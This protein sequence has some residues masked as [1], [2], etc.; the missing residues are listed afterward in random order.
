MVKTCLDLFSG[1]GGFS[2]AFRESDTWK[3]VKVDIR[4]KFN[5]DLCED[6]LDLLPTDLPDADVVL[7]SPPCVCF[8]NA[9]GGHHIDGEYNPRTEKAENHITLAFHTVGL[10]HAI[11]PDWWFLENPTAKLRHYLGEPEGK[12]TYCQYG[13]EYMKPTDLWGEHPPS[14][15]YRSCSPGGD[16]HI[17]GLA[18]DGT[19]ATASLPDSR[20]E[21][22]KVPYDLSLSIRESVEN[23][24]VK[25]Q[26]VDIW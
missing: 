4:E 26:P 6:V 12:V 8:T 14:F 22:A 18:D 21:R 20:E 2:Q 10:I 3:V 7:A 24:Q 23:P 25:S 19:P 9:S 17:R 5:P 11:N 1:L 13:T 15:E 16:C